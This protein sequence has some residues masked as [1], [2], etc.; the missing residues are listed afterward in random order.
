MRKK[1]ILIKNQK[2][3]NIYIYEALFFS[4]PFFRLPLAKPYKTSG[5]G[6]V[7]PAPDGCFSFISPK[8]VPHKFGV[9]GGRADSC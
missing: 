1:L 4:G 8:R 3:V 2:F 7:V 6:Y 9:N 5:W